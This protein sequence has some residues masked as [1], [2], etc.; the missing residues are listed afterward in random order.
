MDEA[1]LIDTYQLEIF[2]NECMHSAM[3]LQCFAH[4]GSDVS[5]ALPYLN[6]ALGGYEYV[7]EPPAVTFRI[8]GKLITVHKQKIAINA[9]KDENEAKK[10]VEWLIREIND[11][12]EK[13][14]KIKPCYAGRPKPKLIEILKLLPKTNCR[15]CGYPTCMVFASMVVEGAKDQ[16]D[17]PELAVEKKTKLAKYMNTFQL[18]E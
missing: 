15:K 1:M 6:A 12:W 9:L 2:N 7:T 14:E 11:A 3:S 13:R 17:C 4:L 10:I 18:D 5:Q 16:S 8:Q